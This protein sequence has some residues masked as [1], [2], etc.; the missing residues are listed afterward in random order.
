MSERVRATLGFL[1]RLTLE[2][3]TVGADDVAL[4]RRAG[5]SDRAI[6]DAIH[7][8]ADALG[9]ELLSERMQASAAGQT[10]RRASRG[11]RP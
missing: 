6:E 4:L 10:T 8:L 9:F 5:V 2:P 7:R 1:E 3:A 11:P